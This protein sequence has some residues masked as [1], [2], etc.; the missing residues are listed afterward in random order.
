VLRIGEDG[1]M[2][3]HADLGGVFP[4]FAND[5]TVSSNG[6][7]YVGN[8]GFDLEDPSAQTRSTVLAMVTPDGSVQ[9]VADS[10]HFPNASFITPDGGTLI[11]N[12]TLASR[13]TAFS[14]NADGTLSERYVWAQVAPPPPDPMAALAG[15]TYAPDG[16]C[17]DAEGRLWAADVL[18][19]RV[20]HI[21]VGGKIRSEIAMP[22][23][24]SAFA[25]GLGGDDGKT[26]LITAAPDFSPGPR[27]EA[28]ESVLL[29]TKVEVPR[30]GTQD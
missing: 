24:L 22:D 20:V 18:G 21:E 10:L 25:C 30:I 11:V 4:G 7:A 2:A 27:R 5:M 14:I 26:L 8:F 16:G 12:E 19:R 1:S 15:L 17:L 28:T 23:G 29:T 3:V 9:V 6:T 13:H